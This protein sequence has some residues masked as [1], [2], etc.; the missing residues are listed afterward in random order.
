VDKK[1]RH[2]MFREQWHLCLPNLP[3]D[4][5]AIKVNHP[6]TKLGSSGILTCFPLPP[7]PEKYPI[8]TEDNEI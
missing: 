7:G 5:P 8:K 4:S 6:F 3:L 2:W 1:R